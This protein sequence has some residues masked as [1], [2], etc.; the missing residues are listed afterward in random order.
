MKIVIVSDAWFPQINGVVTSLFKT[1]QELERLDHQI[2]TP[3]PR[4][5]PNHSLPHLS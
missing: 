4:S 2:L 1:I 3:T 5:V